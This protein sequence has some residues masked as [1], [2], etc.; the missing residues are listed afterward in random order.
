MR[1]AC[2]NGRFLSCGLAAAGVLAL[3]APALGTVK[4]EGT[5]PASDVKVSL[6]VHRVPRDEAIRKLADAAGWSVV[7]H[8]PGSDP[9]DVH[10]KDQPASKV[11]ELLLLDASYVATRDGTLVSIRRADADGDEASLKKKWA[12]GRRFPRFVEPH[13]HDPANDKHDDNDNDNDGDDAN[14]DD[15]NG[16]D[17]ND[18]P[19][20][21]ETPEP[22]EPPEPPETPDP[23]PAMTVHVDIPDLPDIPVFP[24]HPGRARERGR[25]REVAGGNLKIGK[26]EVAH[27]VTVMGGS[28]DVYGTVTGDIDVMGGAV[29]VHEGARVYGDVSAAGGDIKIDNGGRIDGDL[30]V[31]GG[32]VKRGEKAVIRG[33]VHGS[34][35]GHAAR[36]DGDGD[37]DDPESFIE[38]KLASVGSAFARVAMM[39]VLG[40]ILL[41][42]APERMDALKAELVAKPMRSFAMGILGI[43]GS[44]ATFFILCVTIIGIPFAFIGA[45]L[46]LFG[47]AASMCAVLETAG[48]ALTRHKSQN[49]YVH[50]GVGCLLFFAALSIPYLWSIVL[51]TVVCMAAGMLVSTRGAGLVQR[52][53][54]ASSPYRAVPA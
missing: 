42:L 49:P 27:D 28:L 50:L 25:D 7:V 31:T 9:V 38:S 10:V 53:S 32:T 1:F 54:G 34:G 44:I 18:E 35:R 24:D 16:D 43:L 11:L 29:R 3:A 26:N 48:R 37:G 12:F 51:I 2:R 19:A 20:V 4:R 22:P 13:R 30:D 40:T 52:R 21:P 33:D 14:D 17:S 23:P 36:G 45:V 47:L 39:F 15:N 41:A 6:D 5:W 46:A 8:A